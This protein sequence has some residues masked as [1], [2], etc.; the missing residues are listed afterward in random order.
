MKKILGLAIILL[1]GCSLF[2]PEIQANDKNPTTL[3]DLKDNSVFPKYYTRERVDGS[4][5]V[6]D[7]RHSYRTPKYTIRRN[8]TGSNNLYN[9]GSFHRG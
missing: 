3:Y 7:L 4:I 5:S 6:Y 2:I 1:V 9:S 8:A